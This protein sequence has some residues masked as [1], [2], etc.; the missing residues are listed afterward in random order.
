MTDS[1]A[2][3]V[4]I[5][6]CVRDAWL[7][8]AG[9]WKLF[10]PAAGIAALISQLGLLLNLMAPADAQTTVLGLFVGDIMV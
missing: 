5:I 9:N 7:F 6:A 2:G 10:L 1:T 8:F 3:K 4:P